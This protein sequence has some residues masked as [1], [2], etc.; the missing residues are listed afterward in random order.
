MSSTSHNENFPEQGREASMG[1]EVKRVPAPV[2]TILGEG[3]VWL[4]S[5]QALM[6]VDIF[7]EAIHRLDLNSGE[8]QQWSVGERIGWI[9]GRKEEPGY[10]VG[11]KSGIAILTLEPFH[12]KH[13]GSPEPDRP[14]NRL[15]DAKVDSAGRLWAGSKDDTDTV[16]SGALYRLNSSQSWTRCDDGYRVANGPAFSPDGTTLYHADTGLR[17]VYAF[18]LS[19]S[20]E[21]SNR[22]IFVHF[23]EDWGYP[24][25]MTTDARGGVWIAHWDGGRISRFDPAGRL[26]RTIFLPTKRVTSMV[27]GGPKLDRLFV[28]TAS[29][30]LEDD[31]LAG[32]LF[33]VHTGERGLPPVQ[34]NG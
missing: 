27:F 7:G 31:P 4:P 5:E 30:G 26:D 2:R 14:N 8:L 33:E 16:A 28:T 34:F 1:A 24:D 20:G 10:V 32:S 22:R 29:F 12:L 18:G 15:N 23:E 6:W 21:L 19:A 13:L 17:V 25:G 9:V 11:L 3:P